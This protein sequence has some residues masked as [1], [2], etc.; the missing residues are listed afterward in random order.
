MESMKQTILALPHADKVRLHFFLGAL[1]RKEKEA[2]RPSPSDIIEA[3]E[4]AAGVSFDNPGSRMEM[5]AA[6][7]VAAYRLRH[8]AYM[9]LSAAG[10]LIGRNHATVSYY[11]T[12]M[13]EALKHPAMWPEY[14]ELYEKSKLYYD[15]HTRT[16]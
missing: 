1:I 13:T 8:E 2:A 15:F 14:I 4:K 5:L 10:R 16:I 12:V 9:T 6:R 11:V 7:V 3:V